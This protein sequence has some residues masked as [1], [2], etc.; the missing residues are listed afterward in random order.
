MI[1]PFI[2]FVF[3]N[4]T[5]TKE[6]FLHC[7][8]THIFTCFW[9]CVM[10]DV[11]VSYKMYTYQSRLSNV[12]GKKKQ[13]CYYLSIVTFIISTLKST[14]SLLNLSINTK[15]NYQNVQYVCSYAHKFQTIV[16]DCIV[17]FFCA[18]IISYHIIS[19]SFFTEKERKLLHEQ[20]CLPLDRP[21]F[22]R[23]NAFSSN[24]GKLVNTHE[25]LPPLPVKQDTIVAIVRGKYTYHHYMQDNFNDDGWG[26]AYRSMQTIFSWFR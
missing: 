17:F 8:T 10:I 11:F 18:I 22:R 5:V 14:P 9:Y 1:V 4:R 19:F 25:A 2:L 15:L 13:I 26:C 16:S 6:C 21:I 3:R 23:G 24:P 20:L 12:K 7:K